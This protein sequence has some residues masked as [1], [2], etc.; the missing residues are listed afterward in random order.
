MGTEKSNST[1]EKKVVDIPV[2]QVHKTLNSGDI[3]QEYDT[4]ILPIT[5]E[6]I[7]LQFK[8]LVDVEEESKGA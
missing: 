5:H 8:R 1:L 7:F 4:I 6:V 2:I 3:K